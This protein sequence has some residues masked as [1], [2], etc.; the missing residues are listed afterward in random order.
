MNHRFTDDFISKNF[1]RII[2]VLSKIINGKLVVDDFS[3]V[4][5]EKLRK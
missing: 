4:V 5:Y 3:G 2:L 1:H